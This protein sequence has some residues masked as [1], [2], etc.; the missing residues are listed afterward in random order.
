MVGSGPPLD[1]SLLSGFTFDCRPDCGLCC[2]AS[3]RITVAE[4]DRLR[5]AGKP[6]EIVGGGRDLFLAARAEGGACQ[7]LRDQRCDAHE[8]RPSPCREF[9]IT[10]HVGER[11]QA[12]VVLSCPGLDLDPLTRAAP[13]RASGDPKG[14]ASELAAVRSRVD[15]RTERRMAE[16]VRRRRRIVRALEARGLFRPE[17]EIRSLLRGDL[18]MPEDADFPVEDPPAAEEGLV[19]LPLFFDGRRGPVGFA[20][21]LG[22]WEVVEL[23]ATGGVAAN[24][25]VVPPPDRCPP[26]DVAG[27]RLLRGYLGYWL[28]RDALFGYVL[29]SLGEAPGDVVGEVRAELRRIGAQV[30]S[31]AEVRAKISGARSTPLDAA[32]VA[33][34]IR[35]YDQE[36]LDRP[37]WGD[38]L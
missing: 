10:V 17:D 26:I 3:P 6:A 38:R 28:E 9:P 22:G 20:R 1:L 18:P 32:A 21:G 15:A 8:L 36:A 14:L 16:A 30:L 35:A 27:T 25:G 19:A 33:S 13:T 29:A 7:F 23:A 4:R 34:G 31:R 11:L 12:T 24:L 37:T 2:F 5:A